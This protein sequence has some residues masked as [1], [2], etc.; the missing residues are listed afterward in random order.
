MLSRS[1]IASLAAAGMS[2]GAAQAQ[3]GGNLET[4]GAMKSTGGADFTYVDQTGPYADQIRNSR[5]IQ[6]NR[7]RRYSSACSGV[8]RRRASW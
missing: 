5:P 3:T 2:I 4:L 7:D 6:R 1:I 8:I